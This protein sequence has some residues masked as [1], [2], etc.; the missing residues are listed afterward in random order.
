M[1]P[2]YNR[3]DFSIVFDQVS[4]VGDCSK[5][6]VASAVVTGQSNK[7]YNYVFALESGN[8]ESIII[9]PQTGQFAMSNTSNK[10]FAN[11]ITLTKMTSFVISCTVSDDLNSVEAVTTIVC[12]S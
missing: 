12:Q 1:T 7:I 4:F 6:V 2:L 8:S 10:I 9:S 5:G 3:P 11:I